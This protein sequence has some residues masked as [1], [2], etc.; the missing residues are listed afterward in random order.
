M[1]AALQVQQP[2]AADIQRK[3]HIE[4]MNLLKTED[5]AFWKNSNDLF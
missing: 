4:F 5:Q 2:A 1:Q 3:K